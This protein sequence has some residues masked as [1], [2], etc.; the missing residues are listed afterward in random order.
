MKC[1]GFDLSRPFLNADHILKYSKKNT[2]CLLMDISY[3]IFRVPNKL[4]T[5]SGRIIDV[6]SSHIRDKAFCGTENAEIRGSDKRGTHFSVASSPS[7]RQCLT[8]INISQGF[9]S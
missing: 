6:S 4:P 3:S 9:F 2:Y 1:Q 7:R 5:Q 8:R